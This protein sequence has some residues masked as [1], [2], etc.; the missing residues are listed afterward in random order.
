M[1]D[2]T[3]KLLREIAVAVLSGAAFMLLLFVF[4]L[5]FWQA[6]IFSVMLYVALSFLSS[7]NSYK[8]GNI[9]VSDRE[10][11]KALEETIGIGYTKL[12]T[13]KTLR[14]QISDKDVAA[15]VDGL[16]D[17]S[18][19]IFSYLEKNR[20][21]IMSARKFFSYYMETTCKILTKYVEFSKLG[22]EESDAD[23]ILTKIENV[24]DTINTAFERQLESLMAS[25]MLDVESEM[26]VLESMVKMEGF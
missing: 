25:E 18:G 8:V 7:R 2:N 16:I 11:Y 22:I 14:S 3:K 5:A 4:R 26:S 12:E 15:K 19:K 1:T 9:E 10:E 13:I 20:S 21:K 24:L 17:T 6:L 23:G